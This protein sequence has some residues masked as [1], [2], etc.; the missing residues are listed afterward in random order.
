MHFIYI[1]TFNPCSPVRNCACFAYEK[2]RPKVTWLEGWG[3]TLKSD[4]SASKAHF[5]SPLFYVTLLGGKKKSDIVNY[6]G[7]GEGSSE[8]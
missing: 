3:Q 5:L 6:L 7:A 8:S 1:M 4:L 2:M